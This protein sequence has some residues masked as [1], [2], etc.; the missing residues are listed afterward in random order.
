MHTHPFFPFGAVTDWMTNT[1][2]A[3]AF[4][5]PVFA[6]ADVYSSAGLSDELPFRIDELHHF[7]S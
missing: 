5:A 6:G 3:N 2:T 1:V 4:D 7:A